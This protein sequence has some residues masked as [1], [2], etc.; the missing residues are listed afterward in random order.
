MRLCFVGVVEKLCLVVGCLDILLGQG[1]I[2]FSAKG[3]QA[4]HM[5]VIDRYE[6][7]NL[8]QFG[9]LSRIVLLS[10]DEQREYCL[11]CKLEISGHNLGWNGFGT[12]SVV[13]VEGTTRPARGDV[14]PSAITV[15]LPCLHHRLRKT[16]TNDLTQC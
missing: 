3:W 4:K 7:N 5:I 6:R 13:L 14:D 16:Y 11:R 2:S 12:I 15:V 8:H 10:V 9:P 1:M